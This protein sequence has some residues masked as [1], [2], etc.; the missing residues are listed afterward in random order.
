MESIIRNQKFTKTILTRLP[1]FM[2][3]ALAICLILVSC[4]E[5]GPMGPQG[6]QGPQ[7]PRGLQGPQGE[8]GVEGPQGPQG[9]QGEQ[10]AE[11]PQGEQGPEGPQGPQGPEGEQGP[12]G[13]S[14]EPGSQPPP[15]EDGTVNVIYSEWIAFSLDNWTDPFG[16]YEQI[17]REFP[18]KVSEIDEEILLSGTVMVYVRFANTFE[19]IQP[20]PVFGPITKSSEDQMLNYR[21]ESGLIVMELHNLKNRDQDPGR[22]SSLNEFRYIIIPGGTPALKM[23]SPDLNDYY[24]VIRYYG[25]NL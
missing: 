2:G 9:P 1:I 14:G 22:I 5:E 18:V 24:E 11:G 17:R 10:G 13:S 7:G 15:G 25:I 16:Y 6:P 12:D 4:G 8:Q 3:A 20:L 21:L 19:N 23:A